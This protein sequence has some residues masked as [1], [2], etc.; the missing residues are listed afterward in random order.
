MEE[1]EV[2]NS[3]STIVFEEFVD[4]L[5]LP[6]DFHCYKAAAESGIIGH[7]PLKI[8][9]WMMVKKEMEEACPCDVSKIL[10]FV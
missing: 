7:S 10:S 8:S 1:W 2:P 9:Q 5:Q 4:T 6:L 3:E